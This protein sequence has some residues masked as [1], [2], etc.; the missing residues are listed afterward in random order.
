LSPAARGL[1]P[2]ALSRRGRK[3][4]EKELLVELL[5]FALG[6]GEEQFVRVCHERPVIAAGMVDQRVE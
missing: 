3:E 5:D 2:G 1:R 6:T 4:V